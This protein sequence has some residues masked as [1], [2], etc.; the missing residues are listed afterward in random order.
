MYYIYDKWLLTKVQKL[1]FNLLTLSFVKYLYHVP[2]EEEE[3]EAIP[4]TGHG[5][6]C[7]MLRIPRCLDNRLIV[8]G[9]VVSPTHRPHSTPQKHNFVLMFPVLIS[10]RG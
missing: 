3:E 8:G 1:Y 6:L 4:L 5:G 7:E 10:V 9:K 2:Y